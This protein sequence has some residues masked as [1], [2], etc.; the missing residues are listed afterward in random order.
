MF[1]V[2]RQSSGHTGEGGWGAGRRGA[3]A[4]QVQTWSCTLSRMNLHTLAGHILLGGRFKE[5]RMCSSEQAAV[6]RVQDGW[7]GWRGQSMGPCGEVV[8]TLWF[9][10]PGGACGI[11]GQSDRSH[12]STI[13]RGGVTSGGKVNVLVLLC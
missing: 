1:Q 11:T 10:Q 7:R 9:Q 12:K 6:G 8:A 3:V 4:G 13:C 5:D 2:E